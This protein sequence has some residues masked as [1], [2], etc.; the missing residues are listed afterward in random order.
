MATLVVSVGLVS[1]T[2]TTSSAS[3]VNATI[4]T[5]CGARDGDPG[6]IDALNQAAALIGSNRL[7]LKLTV[8]APDIPESAGLDQEINARFNVTA[9]LDQAL[10]D[11]AAALIPSIPVSNIGG[12]LLVN[13]PSSVPSFPVSAP[14][15]TLSPVAGQ[16][17]NVN[18]G[19]VGGPITTTGGGIITYRVGSV[20][21]DS[22]LSVP[23]AGLSFNLKLRCTVQGSNLIARTTVR[24]PDAPV[25]NP[26]VVA[27]PANA[28]QTVTVD[29]LNDVVTPGKTPLLP[30]SLEIV[31]PPSAGTA[32]ISGGVFSFVAPSEPGTYSTTVQVCGAPKEDS[33][34]PGVTEEQAITLGANWAGGG[35]GGL[36]P[37]PVAFSLKVGDD[38]ETPLIW[39]INGR[40]KP[41]LL[42]TPT[43]ENWAPAN[44][45]GEIGNYAFFTTYARPTADQ[46]RAALE[47]VP[48]IGAGNV[49]V[50][51]ITDESG[52]LTGFKIRY[53]N[54]R[55]EQQMPNISLGQWYG[56]PPQEVLDRLLEAA[57]G[58]IGGDGGGD[59]GEETP[60]GPFADLDP[61]NPA[62]Q[63]KADAIISAEFAAGRLPSSEL[64]DAYIDF[65]LI[66]PLLSAV[67]EILAFINSLFPTKVEAETT[68]EGEDPTP[69]QPLCAQGII[70][71]TVAEVASATTVPPGG[72]GTQ[73]GG[74]N[75]TAGIG[76]VG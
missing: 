47:A 60:A 66:Q 34:I 45:A 48:A 59:G 25:F 20:Q 43:P 52:K 44:R 17:A 5:S 75:Q 11:G 36:S 71:I 6:T 18:L 40:Q 61:S 21:F 55:A 7:A 16:P 37:R 49:E 46:I 69:P 38:A 29:L 1:V 2:S 9:T 50:T 42:A 30:E 26:E 64:W 19:A 72:A 65:K 67:P 74:T 63:R 56:V 22:S 23:S 10:I 8:T 27:L 4:T 58:L 28:G 51:E 35:S 54:E 76:F 15:T 68:T 3:P 41:P 62:D 14:N 12:T 33:G 73:V 31:S 13:G 70:D 24:D 57:T 32:S 39:T 53:I